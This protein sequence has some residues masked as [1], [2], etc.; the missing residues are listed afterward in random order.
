MSFRFKE[1]FRNIQ[2]KG[3]VEA[4]GPGMEDTGYNTQTPVMKELK[5]TT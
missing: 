1:S 5:S 3:T 2:A 4:E